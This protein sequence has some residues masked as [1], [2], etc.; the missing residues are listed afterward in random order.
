MYIF[1]IIT[2]FC[3]SFF[4]SAYAINDEPIFISENNIFSDKIIFDGKWTYETEWKATTL[5]TLNFENGTKIHFRITHDDRFIYAFFDVIND[6]LFMK[7]SDRALL[8]LDT[9]DNQNEK[10]DTNDYCFIAQLGSKNGAVFQGGSNLPSKNYYKKISNPMD[11]IAIGEISDENDRYSKIPHTSYEFRIPTELTGRTDVYG[12]FLQVYDYPSGKIYTW[13]DKS[14]SDISKPNTWGKLISPTK[15]I[16][17]FEHPL[18]IF[19]SL[20]A[21]LLFINFSKFTKKFQT[22]LM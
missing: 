22:H 8:C 19:L 18:I 16:P 2:L 10:P 6:N 13:P 5:K 7:I 9:V 3:L 14:S 17:E 15:S 12:I 21:V 1:A 4:L 20:S 11:Y